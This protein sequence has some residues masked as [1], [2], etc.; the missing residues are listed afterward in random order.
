M[1]IQKGKT[2]V[3]PWPEI[4]IGDQHETI[5]AYTRSGQGIVDAWGAARRAFLSSCINDRDWMDDDETEAI[6]TFHGSVRQSKSIL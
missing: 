2:A 1:S 3:I 6:D 4:K 5:Q